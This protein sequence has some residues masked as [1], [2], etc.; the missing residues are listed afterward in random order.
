M[1][2]G[3]L[4]VKTSFIIIGLD[5]SRQPYLAPEVEALIAAGKVFSGGK[6]HRE[7]IATLLPSSYQWIDITVPL[8]DVFDAYKS[9]DEIIVFAS[10]DPLF[11]GFANT[12]QK[13]LPEADIKVF[14][15]FNSLQMLAHKSVMPYHDMYIVSLTGRNWEKFDEALISGY[16]KIGVL[17]D[18][19]EHTPAN[20][21]RYMLEYGYDNYK[22]TVGE[23]LG[24]KDNE[25]ISEVTLREAT[26]SDFAYPN[27]LILQKTNNRPRPFGIPESE[28]NLL[29]GRAKMITKMPVRLVS[30]NML[31][32]RDKSVFWDIGTCTGSVAIEAK[33]QFPH[34]KI[35]AFEKR[36]EGQELL[37][38]NSKKFGTPG[39][40]IVIDDFVNV[41]HKEYPR[42]D[43]V[44]IGG[45][46][47]KMKE[48]I[49]IIKDVLNKNGTIVFNSVSEESR[50]LFLEKL[51]INDL[52]LTQTITIKVDSHNTI[53]IMQSYKR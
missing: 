26:E 47:G 15:T 38:L 45:H 14:P 31:D 5:D 24:N 12:I 11:Y 49:E 4:K 41:N 16:D 40:E 35:I 32:L 30:L 21:A 33:L 44:F 28:F 2:S 1:E 51:K 50:K 22:M 37:I 19:K 20:I 29:N 34:L 36:E 42:P 8:D 3:E 46:G 18:N 9:F 27:N 48:I 17:T 6:R 10:G 39:I 25:K 43:A 7:I 23:L 53:E 52:Q 13:R